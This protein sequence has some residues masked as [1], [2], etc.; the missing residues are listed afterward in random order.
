M[1]DVEK[2][3]GAWAAIPTPFRA[4]ETVD[5]ASLV[6]HVEFL[7]RH[8]IDG[9]VA[10]A[11]TGEAATMTSDEKRRVLS[12]VLETVN[13]RVPVIAGIGTNDTRTTIE[14]AYAAR[15]EGV[16]GLL[17]VTPYYNKPNQEGLLNH[18]RKVAD[19]VDLPNVLYVV[20]GRTGCRC[21]PETIGALSHHPNIVGVKD[22]T[23]DMVA[24]S[25]THARSE[26]GFL[27][28]SGDDGTTMPFIALGGVGAISVVAN[29]APRLMH[30]IIELTKAGQW[31]A[32]RKKHESMLPL[33]SALF[34]DTS[35]IPLKAMLSRSA[36]GY[37]GTLRSPLYAMDEEKAD[38]LCE[39]FK[40]W[41]ETISL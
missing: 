10:T 27:M 36:L 2:W 31:E 11:T 30:D 26:S 41:L 17:V 6:R 4:D 5:E 16:D 34:S 35:P 1:V 40:E 37:P 9:I 38:H 23:A 24:A 13:K 18:F 39:P 19:A 20:P 32:A 22:A 14:N 8:H 15:D 3:G 33:F 29:L 7:C 25:Q 21:F 12:L 28:F